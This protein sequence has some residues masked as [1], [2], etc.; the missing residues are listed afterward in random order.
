MT[1]KVLEVDRLTVE[2]SGPVAL[3]EVSFSL[4]RGM[5]L[6]IVGESGSGKTLTCRTLLGLERRIGARIVRGRIAI[7][8]KDVAGFDDAAWRRLRGRSV[9][10]VPQASLSS[11]DPLMRVGRQLTETIRALDPA[12]DPWRRALELLEQVEMPDPRRVLRSRAHELSGGMRQRVMIA[13]ALAGRPSVLIADEPTTALDS[14]V[15]H[16]ILTLLGTLC[17]EANM[18]MILVSHDLAAVQAI[19][20]QLVVMYAGRTVESGP[21]ADIF[22]RPAH[23]YTRALMAARPANVDR[24]RPLAVLR[25]APPRL[26]ERSLGC[27]FHPRCSF[28]IAECAEPIQRRSFDDEH[29]VECIRAGTI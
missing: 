8:G 12:V 16:R 20:D 14:T 21:I 13:L 26:G 23:P 6:G 3:S 29:T 5:C 7:E 9:A 22:A 25:G 1:S 11:L 24:T 28:A 27:P 10:L 18:A 2:L 17:K 15:Q 19:C 4:E